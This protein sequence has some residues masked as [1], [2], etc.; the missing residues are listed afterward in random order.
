M[1]PMIEHSRDP[2]E[3]ASYHAHVYFRPEDRQA[4]EWIRSRV[5]EHFVVQLGWWH[6]IEVG[7]HTRTR[8]QISF[9]CDLF[10]SLVPWLML[11]HHGL[12][13][14]IHPNIRNPRRDHLEDAL[15]IGAV[16]PLQA[17]RLPSDVSEADDAGEPNTTPQM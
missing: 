3:I 5:A 2:R 12:S 13:I 11:N 8:F 4:A 15:W 17:E 7:P 10:A 9:E 6:E 1:A 16:L 14:L